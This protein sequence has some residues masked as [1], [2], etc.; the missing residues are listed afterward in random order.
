MERDYR[1]E[2]WTT[3]KTLEENKQFA[4]SSCFCMHLK[5]LGQPQKHALVCVRVQEI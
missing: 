2:G 4:H 1:D 3:A 5:P